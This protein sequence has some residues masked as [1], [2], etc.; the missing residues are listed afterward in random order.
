M[1]PART[2]RRLQH[3]EF[4]KELRALLGSNRTEKREAA[5]IIASELVELAN[6][7][8]AG[9]PHRNESRL[10][11]D[12][13]RDIEYLTLYRAGQSIRVYFVTI[14]ATLWMLAVNENKR[15]TKLTKGFET[16]LCAR[17][18]RVRELASE[19]DAKERGEVHR[20]K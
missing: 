10:N 2:F 5:G 11:G 15:Q 18:D 3:P 12:K 20:G 7:R 16:L 17:H 14:G 1:R 6:A 9:K 19:Q 4:G 8:A 13:L